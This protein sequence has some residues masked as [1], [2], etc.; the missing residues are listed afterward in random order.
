MG[1]YIYLVHAVQLV[2]ASRGKTDQGGVF[3]ASECELVDWTGGETQTGKSF[4]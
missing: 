2:D 4:G 1:A 3:L